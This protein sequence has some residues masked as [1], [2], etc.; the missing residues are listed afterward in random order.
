MILAINFKDLLDQ[1]IKETGVTLTVSADQLSAYIAERA[2]VLAGSAGLVGFE[3]AVSAERDNVA[4][5][6]GLS[7]HREAKAADQRIIGLI[8]GALSIAAQAAAAA[9]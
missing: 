3:L 6:A 9:L 8:Q 1:A 2:A 7:A 4:L 5:F